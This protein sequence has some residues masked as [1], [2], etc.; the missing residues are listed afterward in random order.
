MRRSSVCVLSRVLSWS[1]FVYMG[2]ISY[3]VYLLQLTQI[4][5]FMAGLPV[6]LFYVGVNILSAL[7][8][9]F[10]EEPARKLIS[11]LGKPRPEPRRPA[12]AVSLSGAGK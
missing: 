4:V 12:P 10:V 5:W 7:L 1:P 3:A 6:V 11:S 2:R 9:Q 8:Y